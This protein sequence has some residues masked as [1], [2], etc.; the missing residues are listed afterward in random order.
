MAAFLLKKGWAMRG[1]TECFPSLTLK[2][3]HPGHR[4]DQ[5]I[6]PLGNDR[7]FFRER[8]IRAVATRARSL[9]SGTEQTVACGCTRLHVRSTK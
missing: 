5:L 1:I 9:G 3:T 8:F 6:R 7:V 4:D 2:P